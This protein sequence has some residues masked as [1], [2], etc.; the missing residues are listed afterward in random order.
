MATAST[1]RKNELAQ[2]H[3]AKGELCLDDETYRDMLWQVAKVRSASDLDWAGRKRVLDHF[4]SKGWKKK[5]A[6][7]AGARPMANDAQAKMIRGLWIELHQAGIVEDGSEAALASFIKRQARVEALQ[8]L[9]GAQA[10]QV[11]ESLKKWLQRS[12]SAA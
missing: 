11:I 12:R 1:L 5:P 7:K 9:S 8:W 6:K 2:I 10:S 3:I 4:Q